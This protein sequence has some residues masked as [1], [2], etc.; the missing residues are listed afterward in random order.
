MGTLTALTVR[1]RLTLCVVGEGEYVIPTSTVFGLKE[2]EWRLLLK[3]GL[4]LRDSDRKNEGLEVH[5]A[6]P[7][8]IMRILCGKAG[9]TC[10]DQVENINVAEGKSVCMWTLNKQL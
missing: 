2:E 4:E 7:F 1:E 9:W 10:S 6:S 3:E 8:K 5:G